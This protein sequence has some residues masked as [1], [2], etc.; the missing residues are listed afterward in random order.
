[1][2][3]QYFFSQPQSAILWLSIGFVLF[4]LITTLKISELRLTCVGFTLI[5]TTEAILLLNQPITPVL[6]FFS[7]S[8]VAA[9][10]MALAFS[11]RKLRPPLYKTGNSPLPSWAHWIL[12]AAVLITG[13][14]LR[15][16]N[17]DMITNGFEG[18]LSPYYAAATSWKGIFLA[19]KGI[20][21]PWAPLGILFYL[22]IYTSIKI[23][24]TTLYAVRFS[25]AAVGIFTILILYIVVRRIFTPSVAL[26]AAAIFSLDSMHI[27]WS[28]TD[29]HPHGVTTWP[30]L[31]ILLTTYNFIRNRHWING[32]WLISTMALSWH[33]YPSG[34]SAVAIPWIVFLL[35]LITATN[36]SLI[37]IT[38]F[39]YPLAGSALWYLGL[40]VSYFFA[41]FKEWQFLNP[42]T[43]T[44]QRTSWGNLADDSILTAA[45]K[46]TWQ[47]G[48]YFLDFLAGLVYQAPFLFHQDFVIN[49]PG[50]YPRTYPFLLIPFLVV[51]CIVVLKNIRDVRYQ[52]ILAFFIAAVLPGILAEQ[53]YPKRMSVAYAALDCVSAIGAYYFYITTTEH[54]KKLK[55]PLSIFG[56]GTYITFAAWLSVAW[57][58]GRQFEV[59]LPAEISVA[60]A[61][62]KTIQP[63]TLLTIDLSKDYD[64]GKMIFLLLDSVTSPRYQP[65]KIDVLQTADNELS[66]NQHH[67]IHTWS[68][69]RDS[70]DIQ[71]SSTD[72]SWSNRVFLFQKR[73]RSEQEIAALIK[74]FAGQ[75]RPNQITV[76][77]E[78]AAQGT[79]TNPMM[80][81]QCK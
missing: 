10:V 8:A 16:Y 31:L 72:P 13:S 52:L 3:S 35:A 69:L 33:Q 15:L 59:G 81:V 21:G 1:M 9:A 42:F 78:F 76:Q 46:V 73:D 65:I 58:S 66:I 74:A 53:P 70:E 24:G 26:I 41:D 80:L 57:F 61:I 45:C 2:L 64:E 62:R 40:P 12:L 48:Q 51:G 19:N 60:E 56:I 49:L 5:I 20:N 22:P 23:F 25:S 32:M 55:I 28:R 6:I 37:K 47:A 43:L 75:C 34:Q 7:F 39:I 30:A 14:V 77:Q 54:S 67:W 38:D 36:G 50:L 68:A 79:F 71:T 44:T 11:I 27:G 63:H 17:L 4:S 18:E 29:I